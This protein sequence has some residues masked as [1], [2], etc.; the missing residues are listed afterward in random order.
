MKVALLL[1]LSV[2]LLLAAAGAYW[3]LAGRRQPSPPIQSAGTAGV[4]R[5]GSPELPPPE[6]DG[7]WLNIF[8]AYPAAR[9]LCSQHVAGNVMHILWHAYVTTDAP[10][11][12]S[13]FYRQAGRTAHVEVDENPF[14]LRHGDNVLSV[15]SASAKDYPDCGKAPSPEDKTVIIVSQAIRG[16]R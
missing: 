5:E 10:E 13:A 12:V 6:A 4:Q 1:A 2:L 11:E 9:G 14:K 16:R 8:P 3:Y 15:H 7:K